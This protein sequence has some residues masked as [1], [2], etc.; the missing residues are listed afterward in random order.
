MASVSTVATPR[1]SRHDAEITLDE[2]GAGEQLLARAGEDDPA[3]L[4]D[5]GAV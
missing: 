1:P 3:A 5:V 4:Q 2:L